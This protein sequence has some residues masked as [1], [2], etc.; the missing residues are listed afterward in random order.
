[1]KFSELFQRGRRLIWNADET[2]LNAAKRFKV[3]CQR[4]QFPLVT[5]L[6][7]L[8]HLTG[9]ISISR[10]GTVLEPIVSLKNFQ[11][12]RELTGY[13]S[14]CHFATSAN[15]WMSMDIWIY[16]ALVS[17]AQIGRDRLG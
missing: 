13:E 3:I 7:H 16:Y 9:M 17:S 12:L 15:G 4:Q 6:E 1:V 2:E 11:H 8:A 10:G 5:V 14:E